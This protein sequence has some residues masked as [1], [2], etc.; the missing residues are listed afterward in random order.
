[1]LAVTQRVAPPRKPP[2][3][4]EDKIFALLKSIPILKPGITEEH[5]RAHANGLNGIA[6]LA[7]LHQRPEAQSVGARR[8]QAELER[9][10]GL[11]EKIVETMNGA[12]LEANTLIA[13]ALPKG[14]SLSQ[15]KRVMND[16]IR[17][18][19]Q[20]DVDAAELTA[21]GEKPPD[22]FAAQVTRGAAEAFIALTGRQ[23]TVIVTSVPAG[24]N[25]TQA[26]SG[27]PFLDFLAALFE[28][29]GIDASADY[30]ARQL[31]RNRT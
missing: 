5:C 11:A 9:L 21:K 24:R 8:T 28:A 18:L 12:H 20:A 13:A 3:E 22:K 26:K 23:A 16:V 19:H 25:G 1:M 15:Y 29:L 17:V 2:S 14:K 10:S 30:H 31:R 4:T 7:L 27:G 6:V